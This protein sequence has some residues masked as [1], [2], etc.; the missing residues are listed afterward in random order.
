MIM[1]FVVIEDRVLAFLI[2]GLIIFCSG[3]KHPSAYNSSTRLST[4]TLHKRSVS[5]RTIQF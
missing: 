5:D 1:K 3:R 4:I 2:L